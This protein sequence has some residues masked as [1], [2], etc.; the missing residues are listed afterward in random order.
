MRRRLTAK[1]PPFTLRQFLSV[2]WSHSDRISKG[3]AAFM[4]IGYLIPAL[5]ATWLFLN[6]PREVE[7]AFGLVWLTGVLYLFGF[8]L[9]IPTKEI[10]LECVLRGWTAPDDDY[11]TH[12]AEY[13]DRNGK[14][15][16]FI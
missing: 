1:G 2:V 8:G 7:Y 11:Y 15:G 12:L 10:Y 3:F 6:Y 5:P 14:G 16:R 13:L 9:A 4:I